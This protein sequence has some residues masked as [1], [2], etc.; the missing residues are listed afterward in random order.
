MNR[1]ILAVLLLLTIRTE[2][3]SRTNVV[4]S[5]LWTNAATWSGGVVPANS[6]NIVITNAFINYDSDPGTR[7][8]NSL[9]LSNST[10]AL[11]GY[12]AIIYITNFTSVSSTFTNN[13]IGVGLNNYIQLK[14]FS[15]TNSVFSSQKFATDN[16]ID[17]SEC[18]RSPLSVVRLRAL[19][20]GNII[21]NSI[22]NNQSNYL[23]INV[24]A[25][26]GLNINN[27]LLI[28]INATVTSDVYLLGNQFF[29]NTTF[30]FLSSASPGVGILG[31]TNRWK[32]SLV[33][34]ANGG[35]CLV[36]GLFA[37]D[38][39]SLFIFDGTT[40]VGL[41]MTNAVFSPALDT[42]Q[43]QIWGVVGASRLDVRGAGFGLFFTNTPIGS[44]RAT[45]S[46]IA[47]NLEVARSVDFWSQGFSVSTGTITNSGSITMSNSTVICAN[48]INNGGSVSYGTSTVIINGGQCN[49]TNLWSLQLNGPSVGLIATN[50]VVTTLVDSSGNG[51][52]G[53]NVNGAISVTGTNGGALQFN[54]SSQYVSTPNNANQENLPLTISV[55]VKAA[56]TTQTT[57]ACVL[58]KYPVSAYNGW[59]IDSSAGV[60]HFCYYANSSNYIL[61][62]TYGVTFGNITT[63]WMHLAAVVTTS[64]ATL[65]VNGSPAATQ[66]WTGTATNATQTSPMLIAGTSYGSYFSGSIDDVRIYNRALSSNEIVNVM[67]F[68]APTN[69][70]VGYWPLDDYTVV[71]VTIYGTNTTTT[72]AG[73]STQGSVSNTI[74]IT[75]NANIILSNKAYLYYTKPF[76]TF[77]G[78]EAEVWDASDGTNY[79]GT[80]GLYMPS[81][82]MQ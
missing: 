45:S 67:N 10:L 62:G 32:N 16:T 72:I 5:G 40:S 36:S 20:G 48:F 1:L 82:G 75:G 60:Y 17:F 13:G 52:T 57:W 37:L 8:F 25:G 3:A 42:R 23:Q 69:G 9:L 41:V 78:K 11:N 74:T 24:D 50:R 33:H 31:G 51:N 22:T 44:P 35:P 63:S 43:F 39:T 21:L 27:G 64:G 55:W 30:R 12:I 18:F 7:N 15:A 80:S 68:N 29:T 6:D 56:S 4:S 53:T 2:A 73:F 38:S 34:R 58:N 28:A 71:P 76:C 49:V 14:T 61:T 77:Q 66:G 26:G 79:L 65:Y 19:T 59:S 70:L 46:L 54:G 47:D 81:G